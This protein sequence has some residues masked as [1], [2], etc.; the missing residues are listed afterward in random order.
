MQGEESPKNPRSL[1]DAHGMAT[2]GVVAAVDKKGHR[3]E[4]H[5]GEAKFSSRGQMSCRAPWFVSGDLWNCTLTQRGREAVLAELQR[6][7][8]LAAGLSGSAGDGDLED[9]GQGLSPP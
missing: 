5:G 2:A 7:N 3:T 8:P 9:L 1:P 4:G 6:D